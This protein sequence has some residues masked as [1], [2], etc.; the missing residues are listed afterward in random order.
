MQTLQAAGWCFIGSRFSRR[1]RGVGLEQDPKR[2][3]GGGVL[4]AMTTV[5]DPSPVFRALVVCKPLGDRSNGQMWWWWCRRKMTTGKVTDGGFQADQR[6]PPSLS[7]ARFLFGRNRL[8]GI[9]RVLG[10]CR[11]I[12]ST[13]SRFVVNMR[14]ALGHSLWRGKRLIG[15]VVP[16]ARRGACS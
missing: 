10:R 14:H 7:D 8:R 13:I 15:C 11:P 6:S 16:R 5:F 12:P 4:R 3:T 1:H 9:K 2:M